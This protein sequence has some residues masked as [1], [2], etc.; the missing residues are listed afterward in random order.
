M[1]PSFDQRTSSSAT[2]SRVRGRLAASSYSR[3]KLARGL[4][5]GL[6]LD[7]PVV[8]VRVLE[9]EE[10]VPRPALAVRPDA[11]VDVLD[12]AGLEAALDHVGASCLDVRDD[13]LQSW[14]HP[15]P[16][17]DRARRAWRGQL[18]DPHLLPETL[19]DVDVETQLLR[20]ELLRP[21]DVRNRDDHD[22]ELEIHAS[23]SSG[24]AVSADI[25]V[26]VMERRSDKKLID[27]FRPS[28]TLDRT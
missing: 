23:S 19:V 12:V 10:R 5:L 15:A 16:D 7:R 9:E 17:R 26:Q 1:K 28:S 22:L 2:S 13:Q 18:D 8:A 20:V 21:V 4:R 14:L 6:L 27:E 11:V 25:G 24:W 3:G